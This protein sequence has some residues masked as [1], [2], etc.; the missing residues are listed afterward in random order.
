MYCRDH[1]VAKMIGLGTA[2]TAFRHKALLISESI[3]VGEDAIDQKRDQLDR[4]RSTISRLE[5]A[6]EVERRSEASV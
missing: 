3:L 1:R 2:I 5:I 6:L 4:V